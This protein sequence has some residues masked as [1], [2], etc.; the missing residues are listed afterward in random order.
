MNNDLSYFEA[1]YGDQKGLR[2][3]FSSEIDEEEGETFS[4]GQELLK[5]LELCPHPKHNGNKRTCVCLELTCP[6][7]GLICFDCLME[8]HRIHAMKVFKIEEVYKFL[9]QNT[10]VFNKNEEDQGK[11]LNKVIEE[12][13]LP[14]LFE[15]FSSNLQDQIEMLLHRV[16]TQTNNEVKVFH[17]IK[18]AYDAERIIKQRIDR[19]SS[20]VSYNE[21]LSLKEI[22]NLTEAKASLMKKLDF[23]KES[24]QKEIEDFEV[25]VKAI[26]DATL[27]T[28]IEME[29][30]K[31][32]KLIEEIVEEEEEVEK[33]I[34]LARSLQ[35]GPAHKSISIHQNIIK[36][37]PHLPPRTESYWPVTSK[38]S[39]R[40]KFRP[41]RE[42]IA[43]LGFTQLKI[44]HFDNEIAKFK[45]TLFESYREQTDREISSIFIKRQKSLVLYTQEMQIKPEEN[46]ESNFM[47]FD[48]QIWLK[49]NC[50]YELEL[51]AVEKYGC[52]CKYG[53][54]NQGTPLENDAI[55]FLPIQEDAEEEMSPQSDKS[56]EFITSLT[57]GLF[58]SLI[59]DIVMT[60]SRRFDFV[61]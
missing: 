1:F 24:F 18:A 30:K 40:I 39:E 15:K 28:N 52:T 31:H 11:S 48:K 26:I 16:R 42:R 54:N 3:L 10:A 25:K 37:L 21:D 22:I 44:I 19:I 41:L 12:A 32:Q 13:N 29:V 56:Y 6:Q 17:S 34:P 45:I 58:P 50:E 23:I 27:R 46:E 7:R 8:S 2:Y 9:Q 61:C 43:L 49:E 47:L 35:I 20:W 51:S 57:E 59:Y 36:R 60:D 55:E 53:L 4:R 33:V 14:F 38:K 5:E